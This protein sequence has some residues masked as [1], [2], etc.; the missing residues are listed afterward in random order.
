VNVDL[1]FNLQHEVVDLFK[2]LEKLKSKREKYLL[3]VGIKKKGTRPRDFR[4]KK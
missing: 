4:N 2:T 3:T 1:F